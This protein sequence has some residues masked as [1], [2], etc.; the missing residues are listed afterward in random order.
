MLSKS[1]SHEWLSQGLSEQALEIRGNF[2]TCQKLWRIAIR[3][4]IE[5]ILKQ[6]AVWHKLQ[7]HL[8]K[9]RGETRAELLKRKLHDLEG[10]CWRPR[11]TG[12]QPRGTSGMYRQFLGTEGDPEWEA[13]N[14]TY[15]SLLLTLADV[16]EKKPY[17][18]TRLPMREPMPGRG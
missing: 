14:A 7:L 2:N 5:S 9:K 3:R 13:H 15:L 8:W 12:G 11:V 1:L 18:T 10:V 6:K 4:L 17:P 16:P